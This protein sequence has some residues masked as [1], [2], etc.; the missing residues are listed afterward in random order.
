MLQ[1]FFLPFLSPLA[2]ALWPQP[3]SYDHGDTVLFVQKDV[4]FFWYKCGAKNV[5]SIAEQIL[6]QQPM[7]LVSDSDLDLG[8]DG[9]YRLRKTYTEPSFQE[10]ESSFRGEGVSGDDIVDYAIKSAWR[11]IFK[12]N[13]YPWQFHP[14]GWEE[15]SPHTHTASIS[16]I[17]V[18]LLTSNS[19]DGAKPLAGTVDE[20]Y[21]LE[22]SIHG[23]ATIAANSSTGIARGL[24][25]LTQLFYAHSDGKHFYTPLAPVHIYDV[26]QFE[27]RGLNLDVARNWFPVSDIKRQI[28]ALAFNKMNHLHLHITDSQSWPLEI[29]ALPE[30]AAKGA[31]RPDL[32]YT[33]NDFKEL[34]RHAAIQGVE[35]ITEID[36][37]GHTSSIWYSFPDLIAAFNKQP[38]WDHW[39]AEPPSGTLKLNSTAVYTFLEKLYADL[40]PRIHPYSRYFHTGGDEVNKNSYL[41]DDTVNSNDPTILQ[42]LVQTFIDWTHAKVRSAGLTPI[43]WEEMLLEWNLTLGPDVIVQSWR[44]NEAVKQIVQ[45]GHKALTGNYQSWYLDCGKGQWLDFSQS[46]SASSW[47]YTDYCAP[48]HNWRLMYSSDPLSG[49]PESLHHLV[50][51]GEAHM[52]AEQTDPVNVDGMIWPRACAVAEVLWSGAKDEMGRNRSQVEASPRLGEMR[53]RLVMKGVGAESIGMP[54]CTMGGGECGLG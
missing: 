32:V 14:R 26:P 5:G 47:P 31:Y 6:D 17:H 46:T 13:L 30:L 36:M 22:L 54:F 1:V 29:P 24:T 52:W 39:A 19:P 53:E 9:A 51:G 20:S 16:E 25:T 50:L 12:Q 48:Y 43:V 40:L 3:V 18:M 7:M 15:P 45:S 11:T 49:V 44:S 27:H 10:F 4:T 28:D 23:K 21:T 8:G 37:P 2:S 35:M 34:Q 33:P 38:D 42:R 41:L